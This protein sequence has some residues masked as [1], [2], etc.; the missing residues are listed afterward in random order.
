MI[1]FLGNLNEADLFCKLSQPGNIHLR[2]AGIA[3]YQTVSL[4]TPDANAL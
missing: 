3:S 1:S 4:R 2:D